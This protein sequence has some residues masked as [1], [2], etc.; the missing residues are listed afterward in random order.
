MKRVTPSVYI[1][2]CSRTGIGVCLRS[3]N[4]GVRIPP[5]VLW[6]CG[7]AVNTPDCLSGDHGFESHLSRLPRTRGEKLVISSNKTKT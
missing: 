2:L 7:V 3:R 1:C 4:L 6:L 5:E